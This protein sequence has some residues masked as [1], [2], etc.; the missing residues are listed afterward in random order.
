MRRRSVKTNVR[1]YG[2]A[3]RKN[4]FK[5][6][7]CTAVL[8]AVFASGSQA[9]S[10]TQFASG[11]TAPQAG[12]I[13]SGAAVNPATG[14]PF[15]HLWSA[16]ATNGLCRLDPDLDTAGAHSINPASC[17][18]TIL[19]N[20]VALNA[21]DLNF[22]PATNNLYAVDLQGRSLGIFR[23]HF[24]PAGDS[25]QGLMDSTHQEVLGGQAGIGGGCGI[26]LNQPQHAA[27]GPDA[28]LYIGFKRNG[29][30]M[31]I[32]AP[33]TEPLPCGNVQGQVATTPDL[34]IDNG[35][36]W[37]GPDLFGTDG[38]GAMRIPN[39][40]Q[41]FTPQNGFVSCTAL[42]TLGGIPAG[43]TMISDQIYP[44]TVGANIYFS[45]TTSV[46]RYA[47]ASV[48]ITLNYGGFG[49]SFVSA[50]AADASV[51]G[52][53]VLYVGDDPT[54]GLTPG[55]GR[56]FRVTP[57]AP[58]PAPPGTPTGVTAVSGDTTAALSWSP[59]PDGQ[60]VTS[61][62]VHNSFT[63]NGVAAPDVV[64]TAPAGATT[65]PTSVT[66]TGLTDGVTYQFQVLASNALGSSALSAPSNS[67]TPF[68]V[69]VPGAPTGVN[70]LT[71]NAQALLVWTA[72]ASDGHSAI[73]SYTVSAFVGGVA[74]GIT[75]TAPGNATGATV[76]GL[77]NG[78]TYTFTVHATNAIGNSAESAPSNA[79]TPV[80]Q[81]SFV[82]D[83]SLTMSGPA[84]AGFLSNASYV[85]T[86]VNNG[87]NTTSA[88]TVVTD[89]FPALGA[90][91]VS[92][93]PSQGVC[94]V[95]GSTITCQLGTM[96]ASAS[97]SVTVVLN[98]SA[99]I[100]NQASV[101]AFDAGGG[102]YTDP[103]PANNTASVTTAVAIPSSTTDVQVTGSAQ[104]GGPTV[105]LTDTYTWQIKNG[106]NQLA[107]GVTFSSTL[108]SSLKFVSVTATAGGI[109]TAPAIGSLGGVITCS[110]A[111]LPVGQTMVVTVSF[112]PT[113]T[114]TYVT[115]GSATFN[116]TD[117][118]PANN[119]F[120]VTI[121]VK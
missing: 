87:P 68:A 51:A 71:S 102:L 88:Q 107:N 36:A 104:N 3:R 8:L 52:A 111:T 46:T 118:N 59:A 70:A 43:P 54:N 22:D 117:T 42:P 23:L 81:Q 47:F 12:V 17:L 60:P 33:Q 14:K 26:G 115:S 90:T 37:V 20:T 95:S 64:V 98:V 39:A 80:A 44:A 67:V 105:G 78:I 25:G 31:R 38:R 79:V 106:N 24:I 96:V 103:T 121:Q 120:S 21:G 108:P 1:G 66:I 77:T 93:T 62:Q 100:I 73:T 53:T 92:A 5:G 113:L 85:L 55:S 101:S 58:A 10:T 114:G 9:Q 65:V 83:M 29:N 18:K 19:L 57:A 35:L 74:T 15:R 49:L 116:G 75:A 40:A 119:T 63:S 56:W 97:A 2:L 91:Y 109:C 61:Y 50:L 89:K 41:C 28:N 4:D 69:T 48:Q 6:W 82:P 27:L 30:I 13:L 32:V 7:A 110:T 16:D 11:L 99:Q 72:P 86:V 76:T 84:S 94:N 45:E 112:A 34:K